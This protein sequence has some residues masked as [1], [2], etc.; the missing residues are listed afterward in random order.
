MLKTSI[1]L[2]C[3][4]IL[5]S[6]KYASAQET[7]ATPVREAKLDNDIGLSYIEAGSGTPVIFIHGT[8]GDLYMWTSFVNS[9][10]KNYHA[11]AY[12]R[13]YNYPNTNPLK[14]NANHSTAVEARDLAAFIT[15]LKLPKAHI[16]GYSYGGYT[17]LHLAVDHPELVR[18]L[19][20]AEPPLMPW[21]SDMSENQDKGRQMLKL[22]KTQF[23]QPARD[24]LAKDDEEGAIQIFI[25]YVVQDGAFDALPK[26]NKDGL[27]RNA[28]EFVAEVTSKNLFAPLSR[29]RVAS[30]TV[31]I[32]MIS[33][34]NSIGPLRLTDEELEKTLP[35][36]TSRRVVIPNAT[37]AM[38]YENPTAC[39][40]VL[41][42]FMRAH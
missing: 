24:A 41:S 5:F 20:L 15:K 21:L 8:L 40:E 9:F 26:S 17:A 12:S 35:A 28:R 14:K 2:A 29:H 11:I 6:A 1:F 22:Q 25:D 30:L 18:T 13:R 23:I 33:G 31:P 27:I 38:W 32:L 10:G 42:T 16:V 36:S 3:I 19:V 39:T 37:H 7:I 4:A 34:E